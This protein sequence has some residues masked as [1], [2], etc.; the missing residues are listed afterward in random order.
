MC[1]IVEMAWRTWNDGW[2]LVGALSPL[3]NYW[4]DYGNLDAFR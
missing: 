2:W 3:A 4:Q 1:S